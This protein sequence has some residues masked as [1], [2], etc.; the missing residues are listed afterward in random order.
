M[1]IF[2]KNEFLIEKLQTQ[3]VEFE[4]WHRSMNLILRATS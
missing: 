4:N 1:L 3:N 2:L